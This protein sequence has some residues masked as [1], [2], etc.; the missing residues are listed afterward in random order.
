MKVITRT[1]LVP[2][3]AIVPYEHRPSGGVFGLN[4]NKARDGVEKGFL[5]LMEIPEGEATFIVA[6]PIKSP[7]PV[8]VALKRQAPEAPPAAPSK[9]MAP[10]ALAAIHIPPNWDGK[11]KDGGLRWWDQVTLAKQIAGRGPSAKM[12]AEEAK[13]T[14]TKEL[15]RRAAAETPLATTVVG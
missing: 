12:S 3:R 10:A 9:T 1:G 2:V 8:A 7:A 11:I 14:I 15:A 13:D 5:Q 6:D 4:P